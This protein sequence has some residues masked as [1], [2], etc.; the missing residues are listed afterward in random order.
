MDETDNREFRSNI[1]SKLIRAGKR[2]YF[3]D[4]KT[5]KAND[6]YLTITESKKLYD[7]ETGKFTIEKYKIFLYPEDF[8]KFGDTFDEIVEL[9]RKYSAGE[10]SDE[11]LAELEAE[12]I[13]KD[14]EEAEN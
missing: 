4:I 7:N 5:T 8:E 2:I 9:I 14:R 11:D 10:I 6:C 3:F 1:F 13:R 12:Q